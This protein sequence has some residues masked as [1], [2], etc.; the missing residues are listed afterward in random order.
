MYV[1]GRL[2]HCSQTDNAPA[3]VPSI[4]WSEHVSYW[5]KVLIWAESGTKSACAEL[6]VQRAVDSLM[7]GAAGHQPFKTY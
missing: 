1:V 5:T 3:L 4:G 2:E 6:L 7:A